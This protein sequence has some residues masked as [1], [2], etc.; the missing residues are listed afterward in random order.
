M[1]DSFLF[2]C[3]NDQLKNDKEIA[4]VA[5]IRHAFNFR[6]RSYD[7]RNDRAFAL[8][9]IELEG[10]ILHL[11]GID[12]KNDTDQQCCYFALSTCVSRL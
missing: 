7:L 8:L 2:K 4:T 9:A 6:E 3:A 1:R 11:V 5:V 10:F 12:L